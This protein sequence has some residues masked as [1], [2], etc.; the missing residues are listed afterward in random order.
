M[1]PIWR[2]CWLGR[3]DKVADTSRALHQLLASTSTYCDELAQ[4]SVVRPTAPSSSIRS[5]PE[6]Y[7][8]RGM[9]RF[10]YDWDLPAARRDLEHAIALNPSYA[11]QFDAAIDALERTLRINPDFA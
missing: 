4:V 8:V 9:V 11:R 3:L 7:A 2:P 5:L 1:R 6:G 10:G